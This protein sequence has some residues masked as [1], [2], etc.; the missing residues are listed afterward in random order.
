MNLES[1]RHHRERRVFWCFPRVTRG[2][3][4]TASWDRLKSSRIIFIY[5]AVYKKMP[6]RKRF[7]VE[8]R[9]DPDYL[10]LA[11]KRFHVELKQDSD[12][13]PLALKRLLLQLSLQCAQLWP[14]LDGRQNLPETS[15]FHVWICLFSLNIL[16]FTV[17][18]FLCLGNCSE[19]IQKNNTRHCRIVCCSFLFH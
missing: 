9:Q 13:L 5:L 8:L 17:S 3:H 19:I 14:E 15:I 10:A 12:Y 11:L 4:I 18:R 7:K 6:F 16:A 2:R 1:A